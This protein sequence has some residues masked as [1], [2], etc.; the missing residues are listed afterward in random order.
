MV[1][2]Y[3]SLHPSNQNLTGR[4]CLRELL[5]PYSNAILPSGLEGNRAYKRL[6]RRSGSDPDGLHIQN[7][8]LT[9]FVR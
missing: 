6:I 8:V 7:G 4:R 9:C 5:V 3:D 1:G 2:I